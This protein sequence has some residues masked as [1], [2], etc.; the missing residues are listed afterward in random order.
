MGDGFV[1][2]CGKYE[3]CGIKRSWTVIETS[4]VVIDDYDLREMDQNIRILGIVDVAKYNRC[5][6]N[7]PTTQGRKLCFR[8]SSWLAGTQN[9]RINQPNPIKNDRIRRHNRIM[10][11]AGLSRAGW[12]G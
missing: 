2:D 8:R 9:D 6:Q 5:A 4:I 11:C 3:Y 1:R 7:I 10:R 12:G